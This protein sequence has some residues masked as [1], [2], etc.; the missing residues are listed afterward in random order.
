ATLSERDTLTLYYADLAGR[1]PL[2]R[3]GEVAI[4]RRI[5]EAEQA[6]IRAW[7]QCPRARRE[8]ALTADDVKAG[9]LTIE[10]LLV[11]PDGLDPSAAEARCARL[12]HLLDRVRTTTADDELV[13]G[14]ADLPLD[15]TLGE[16]IER[17]LR[18]AA[19]E[20]EAAE[21][22]GIEATLTTIARSRRAIARARSE[23]VE[24]NLRLSM[25]IARQLSRSDV[26]L[27][28]LAQEGNLGLM[29]AAERFDYRRG[30]RFSTYAVW[31]IKQSIRRALLGQGRGLRMPAHLAEARSRIARIRRE[32]ANLQGREP[33]PE[34]IAERS[35]VPLDRVRVIAEL[36]LDP[37][38]L[39]AP[40]GE[41][42]DTSFG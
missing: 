14:L 32:L 19:P 40:V 15:W 39:D 22:A 21:R 8:L 11:E 6:I 34:E 30:H 33:S 36:A 20:A 37:F 3:E 42:G 17:C 27:I 16:R 12:A 2:T 29:R 35:G 4:G 26:P 10:D 24:A 13:A 25:S 41:D 5:E 9:A 38:S 23:L 18:E 28:D 1:R 31:W 7:L